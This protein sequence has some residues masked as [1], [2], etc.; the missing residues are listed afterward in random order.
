MLGEPQLPKTGFAE[1]Q[2][3]ISQHLPGTAIL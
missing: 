2:A 1:W 3:R